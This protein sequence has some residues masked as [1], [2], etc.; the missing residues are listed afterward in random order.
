MILCFSVSLLRRYTGGAH[1][2]F[3][4]LCTSIGILYCTLFSYISR[5]L[6]GP[7]LT[8]AWI[9]GLTAG[10]YL[11]SYYI[12]YKLV[13]VDS[14][15]KPIRTA[16]KKRRMRKGSFLTLSVYLALS[17]LIIALSFHNAAIKAF[18]VSLLFGVVW[19]IFTLTKAGVFVLT[20]M[21]IVYEKIFRIR[22]EV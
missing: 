11:I 13:P 7:I 10:V 14:P 6:V 3:I 22:K 12:I 9:M 18:Q 17:I 4:A 1:V 8:P 15:R 20:R 5:Y 16:E 2:G 21:N 19:Q